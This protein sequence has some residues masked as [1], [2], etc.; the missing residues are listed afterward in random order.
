VL[1]DGARRNAGG[2]GFPVGDE[3]SG[4]WLGLG[5]MRHAQCAMD[6]RA[7]AGPLATAVWRAC[8]T[9]RETLLAWSMTAGQTAYAGLAP[10]VFDCATADPAAAALLDQAAAA[11]E[12]LA[13]ALDPD[14]HLPVALLGSVGGRLLDRCSARLRA[15]ARPGT[16]EPALAA[17][18]MLADCRESTP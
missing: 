9:R 2:W 12:A 8:G 10:L 18:T 14:E 15:R 1:A 5:A 13:L 17:L 16:I 7:T 4:A 11:L 3:G 6:G